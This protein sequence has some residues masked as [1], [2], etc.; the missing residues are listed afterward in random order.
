MKDKTLEYCCECEQT[1]DRAVEGED[2]LYDDETGEG[3][4]CEEC[5]DHLEE[6]KQHR[7]D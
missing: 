6:E 2:S 7:I 1:T 5:W 3:P 4:Y